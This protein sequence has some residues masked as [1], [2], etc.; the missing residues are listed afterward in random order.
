ML[1]LILFLSK[2]FLYQY[3][4]RTKIAIIDTGINNFRDIA[5][6]LCRSGHVDMTHTGLGDNIGHGT[7]IAYII[8]NKMNVDKQC[9]LIIKF[10]NDNI[11]DKDDNYMREAYRIA[12]DRGSKYINASMYGEGYY[13]G[14]HDEIKQALEKHIYVVTAAGNDGQD[15]SKKCNAY[16]A[17]YAFKSPYFKVVASYKNGVR[18]SFSNYGGPVTDTA[19]GEDVSAGGVTMSGTSQATALVTAQLVSEQ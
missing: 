5:P 7:N 3:D 4:P 9:L 13:F 8:K 18:S 2:L 10:W 17:C 19:N 11:L 12:I 14:E 16:P 1:Y 6:Y 15:L